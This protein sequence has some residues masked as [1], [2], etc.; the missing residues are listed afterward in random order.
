M[1][2][3]PDAKR[4]KRCASLFIQQNKNAIAPLFYVITLLGFLKIL[5]ITKVTCIQNIAPLKQGMLFLNLLVFLSFS[6]LS[7]AEF[8]APRGGS[9]SF[10]ELS[11]MPIAKH[12]ALLSTFFG[13]LG[14]SRDPKSS[15]FKQKVYA[16]D[17]GL[18]YGITERLTL[19]MIL[20]AVSTKTEITIPTLG[21][22]QVGVEGLGDALGSLRYTLYQRRKPGSS[23]DLMPFVGTYFPTAKTDERHPILGKLDQGLQLGAGTYRP[24][25]GLSGVY[26]TPRWSVDGNL[27]GEFWPER[28]NYKKTPSV[29][30]SA[31]LLH[32]LWSFRS[33]QDG[34]FLIGL[35][36]GASSEGREIE[37]GVTNP[38]S[39]VKLMVLGPVLQYKTSHV[40]ADVQ[41]RM[42][43]SGSYR[44]E[45]PKLGNQVTFQVTVKL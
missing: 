45:Q 25:V 12:D 6:S 24:L 13:H 4:N 38:D 42:P 9:K 22:T 43:V 40:L 15:K 28:H 26:S 8:C 33:P 27:R 14:I 17:I 29:F 20:S 35:D 36:G 11:S 23:F 31:T 7:Q 1:A 10:T 18:V 37:D 2:C 44:G 39:G 19:L 41:Y 30:F 3:A 16:Y 21:K 32:T 5:E 34:A